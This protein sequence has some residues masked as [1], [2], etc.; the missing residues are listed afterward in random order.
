MIVEGRPLHEPYARPSLF[1]GQFHV[2]QGAYLLLGDNRDALAAERAHAQG[3]A[4]VTPAP[5]KPAQTKDLQP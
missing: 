4:T 2:P 1:T 3:A 5:V